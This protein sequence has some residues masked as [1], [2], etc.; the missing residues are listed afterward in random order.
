MSIQD[1]NQDTSPSTWHSNG[2]KT[3]VNS[4]YSYEDA[5][6]LAQLWDIPVVEAKQAIGHKILHKIEDLLPEKVKQQYD[7]HFKDPYDSPN[8]SNPLDDNAFQSYLNSGYDYEDAELLAAI[9]DIDIEEAKSTIGYKIMNKL[10]ETLPEEI[11]N[12]YMYEDEEVCASPSP[13]NY[14]IRNPMPIDLSHANIKIKSLKINSIN[15]YQTPEH[16]A[17]GNY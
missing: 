4:D 16:I 1:K 12:R 3:Y 10:E 5:E 14:A 7:N 13:K 6:L 17:L 2:F 9:W 8:H 15:I 11:R